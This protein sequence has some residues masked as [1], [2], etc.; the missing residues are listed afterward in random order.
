MP[1]HEPP[2][3]LAQKLLLSKNRFG[4]PP[5]EPEERRDR[6]GGTTCALLECPRGVGVIEGEKLPCLESLP[7][8]G[9]RE[10]V[11]VARHSLPGNHAGPPYEVSGTDLDPAVQPVRRVGLGEHPEGLGESEVIP[12]HRASTRGSPGRAGSARAPAARALRPPLVRLRDGGTPPNARA[13]ALR[14]G[15]GLREPRSRA[16]T[17]G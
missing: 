13:V 6:L 17:R 16:S 7:G 8:F 5:H 11:G 10:A 15:G 3:G 4:S 9:D 12:R 2:C 14:V 1:S